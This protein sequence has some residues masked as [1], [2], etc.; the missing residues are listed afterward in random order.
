[1]LAPL[2]AMAQDRV[3]EPQFSIEGDAA[4]THWYYLSFG[5]ATIISDQGPGSLLRLTQ[6]FNWTDAFEWCLVKVGDDAAGTFVLKSKNN[7]YAG[8]NGVRF[9]STDTKDNAAKLVLQKD[10]KG[11]NWHYL[12]LATAPNETVYMG[13][14]NANHDELTTFKTGD[15]G[16]GVRFFE[17]LLVP[18]RVATPPALP[19]PNRDTPWYGISFTRNSEGNCLLSSVGPGNPMSSYMRSKRKF[20]QKWVLVNH[21]ND[22]GTFRLMS[23]YGLYIRLLD[24]GFFTADQEETGPYNPQNEMLAAPETKRS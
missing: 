18:A 24:D 21:D 16:Q 3:D 15:S 1:M 17:P 9:T 4:N 20:N 22:G 14:S 12:K 6:N 2:A 23:R 7:H 19:D 10:E 5:A 11:G 8:W 13:A